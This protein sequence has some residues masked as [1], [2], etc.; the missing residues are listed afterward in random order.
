VAAYAQ[1]LN[2]RRGLANA[3]PAS[4]VAGGWFAGPGADPMGIPDGHHD[5]RV[6]HS[7]TLRR[8]RAET[9]RLADQVTRLV[10]ALG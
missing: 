6:R 10:A 7:L 8:V 5:N 3:R 2:S 1:L 9:L 4:W